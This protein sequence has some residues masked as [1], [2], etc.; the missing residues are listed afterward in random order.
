MDR[1][2]TTAVPLYTVEGE[3]VRCLLYENG[4]VSG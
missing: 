1:C 3:Q 4:G 2:H